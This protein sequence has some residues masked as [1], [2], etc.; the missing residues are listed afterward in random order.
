MSDILQDFQSIGQKTNLSD[1]LL[2]I[3]EGRLAR[4]NTLKVCVVEA[5]NAD[6]TLNVRNLVLATDLQGHTIA[7]ILWEKLPILKVQGGVSGFFIDYQV[8]DIVLCG[9]CDRDINGAMKANGASAPPTKTI[10]PLNSGLVLGS[11]SSNAQDVFIKMLQEGIEVNGNMTITGNITINGNITVD[12]DIT[13]SGNIN[14][15]GDIKAGEISLKE[16]LHA[17]TGSVSGA[18]CQGTTQT[19]Q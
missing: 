13:A 8:G 16:H 14:A 9:F 19:P 18:T 2:F 10:M 11:L 5:V 12:G 17:F 4:L 7:S 1:L 15:D 3:I 6:G